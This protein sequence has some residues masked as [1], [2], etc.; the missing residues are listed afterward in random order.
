[1]SSTTTTPRLYGE[2]DVNPDIL[3]GQPIAFLGYGS[4]GRAQALN[5]RDSGFDVRIGV[6]PGGKSAKQAE[7]DGFT[8]RSFA[9]LSGFTPQASMKATALEIRSTYSISTMI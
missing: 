5:L 3:R 7:A 1:M 4:Q 8:V 6:R 9:E 2:Q